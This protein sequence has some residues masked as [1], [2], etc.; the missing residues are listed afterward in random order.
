MSALTVEVRLNV[1]DEGDDPENRHDCDDCA[2][3]PTAEEPI[4]LVSDNGRV[5]RRLCV[6][7]AVERLTE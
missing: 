6:L 7:C 2:H 1:P 5:R 4:V 3:C